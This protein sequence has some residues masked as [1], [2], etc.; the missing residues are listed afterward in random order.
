[1]TARAVVTA[2]PLPAVLPPPADSFSLS[3]LRLFTSIPKYHH[4]VAALLGLVVVY[5]TDTLYREGVIEGALY[6]VEN[7]HPVGGMSWET[8][9]E[10]NRRHG[11]REPRV[12]IKTSRRVIR[13]ARRGN[14]PDNWF[15]V[16]PS[17]YPDG[18]YYDW[19]VC[20][21]MV[22]KVVGIY[23]PSAQSEGSHHA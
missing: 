17:G 9:D 20:Q 3:D 8:Y 12:R 10:F 13:A 1:M 22:G 6:V 15:Q 16:Q 4:D 14:G 2:S 23:S 7:Q 11:P 5:E 18:P 19:A 21:N